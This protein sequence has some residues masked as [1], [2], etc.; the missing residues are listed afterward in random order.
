MDFKFSAEDEAFRKELS[1]WLKANLPK[2]GKTEGDDDG[3]FMR[4]SSADDWKRRVEWHK[5]M[6]AG[7][8]VGISWPKEYG[9]RGATLTQQIIYNEEMAKV[10]SPMLVNG[11]GIMLV[12][13]THYPLGHRGAEEKATSRKFFRP[14]NSGARD[15]PSP[16]P[17]PTW[18]ACRPARSRKA[19]TLS[20]TDRRS[21]P[22]TRITPTCASCWCAPIPRRPST[23]ASATSWSICTA[24]A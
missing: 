13:P 5:K 21:G 6:H 24:P 8:W 22:R 23:R 17:A 3:D 16:A 19:T 9:G 18:P 10:N 4:E 7:G 14:T 20:S 2:A 1:G 15:I 12:G 11:L